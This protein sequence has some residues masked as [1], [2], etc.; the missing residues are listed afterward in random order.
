MHSDTAT[1]MAVCFDPEDLLLFACQDSHKVDVYL[2]GIVLNRLRTS[3]VQPNEPFSSYA[4]LQSAPEDGAA[5]NEN[6]DIS[7]TDVDSDT[8]F[9]EESSDV[10][11]GDEG[12]D[13]SIEQEDTEM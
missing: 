8:L 7:L 5:A 10:S 2:A 13:I 9:L 4:V 11:S 3:I 12:S 6:S 1:Q